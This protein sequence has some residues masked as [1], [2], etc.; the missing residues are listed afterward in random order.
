MILICASSP[1]YIYRMYLMNALFKSLNAPPCSPTT[2]VTTLSPSNLRTYPLSQ[3]S[4]HDHLYILQ[5]LSTLFHPATLSSLLLAL[6]YVTPN[7]G[8]TRP[9]RPGMLLSV[10]SCPMVHSVNIL[11]LQL[12]CLIYPRGF[13]DHVSLW[14]SFFQKYVFPD[15]CRSFIIFLY[16]RISSNSC[17][18]LN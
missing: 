18:T 12:K 5:Y 4:C 17:D 1:P 14:F 6:F 3:L 10:H 2:Q 16:T 13:T 7:S 8:D 11:L 9:D 15:F